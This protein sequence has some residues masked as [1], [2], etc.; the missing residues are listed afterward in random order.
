M[1]SGRLAALAGR[2]RVRPPALI[3]FAVVAGLVIAATMDVLRIGGLETWLARRGLAP[4][5]DARGQLV[6]VE[7]RD[8]YLDC[9][10][11]GAPT[12]VLEAGFGSGA[13]SWGST[14]DGIAAFTRVCAWDRPGIGRSGSRELHSAAETGRLLWTALRSV[15]ERGPYVVVAHSLG[16]VY[17]RVFGADPQI[18]ETPE[19]MRLAVLAFVM[20]DTYEPDLGVAVDPAL[21]ADMRRPVQEALDATGAQIQSVENLDWARTLGELAAGGPVEQPTLFLAIEPRLR[22]SEPD[23]QLQAAIIDA[24]YR[25]IRARYLDLTLEIVPNTGHLIHVERPSL[26]IDR[27]RTLVESLRAD[28]LSTVPG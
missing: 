5:Y 24:W 14:L 4:P 9:R 17:G 18:I 20:I 15:G 28:G 10:G 21:P 11:S 3:A 25:G 23:A 16:G 13:G 19:A 8:V 26:V 12:V 1:S 27:V 2:A 7:G 6:P 22:Y